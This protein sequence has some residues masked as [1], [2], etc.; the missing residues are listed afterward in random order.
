MQTIHLFK[1]ET[2]IILFTFSTLYAHE[3]NVRLKNSS[4]PQLAN[5]LFKSTDNHGDGFYTFLKMKFDNFEYI[6]EMGM[7]TSS[8]DMRKEEVKK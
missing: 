4:V 2:L 7:S 6:N 5:T 1:K 8:Y 3:F